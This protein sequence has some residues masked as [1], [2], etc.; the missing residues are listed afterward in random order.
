MKNF[1]VS[2]YLGEERISKLMFRFSVPCI[3][4]LL[5][6]S[7]YNIVDQIFIGN[8]ELST[9][10]NAATGVVFPIFIIAQAFAWA[11][12]D[13]CAAFLSICQGKGDMEKAH[14]G[15]GTGISVALLVS[16][17]AMA[18]LYPVKEPLLR[19]FGASSN[20][21][22]MATEYFDIVLATFPF[23]VISNTMLGI[24]RADGSPVF[25]MA[26]MIIGA[27][28]NIFLD[29][30]FIFVFKWGMAGAAWA[31]VLGQFVSFVLSAI[32]FFKPKTFK[33]HLKSFIPDFKVFKVP[34]SLGIST[35]I[36]QIT[37]LVV[38]VVSN[39]MLARYGALSVYGADIPIAVFGI[40]S[41]VLVVV[42]N[43]V[44]GI[45]L[46]SQPIISY[47]MGAGNYKRLKVLYKAILASAIVVGLATTVL[48][49]AAP[50]AIVRIFGL[51]TNIPNPDAYWEFSALAFRSYFLFLTFSCIIKVNGIF[52]Q[53][54]GKPV[55]AVISSLVRDTICFI[56]LVL[57]LPHFMGI[58][59][60][61][62]AAPAADFGAMIVAFF[63]IINFVRNVG[64]WEKEQENFDR[65]GQNTKLWNRP[66]EQ[67]I[68][69]EKA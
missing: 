45:V 8:S 15:I 68:S 57:V 30:L 23:F 32:Y 5:V 46:G 50:L 40:M 39:M 53:A 3:L 7:F 12:G 55:A 62:F 60:V 19:I 44:V 6:S 58:K 42:I 59:G 31:T 21:I 48:F 41:K 25:A 22:A 17:L 66:K 10:G 33:L 49:E 38:T 51:P 2:S 18:V 34:A 56:P 24:I 61:L 4:S 28:V 35:F 54:V 43:I 64:R 63:L 67:M 13:G 27:V 29:W 20:T 47:N 9:L 16:L 65:E 1:C 14:R 36:T 11:I 26:S 69:G 52:F 37:V